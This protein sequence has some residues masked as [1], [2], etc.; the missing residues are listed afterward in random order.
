M[1]KSVSELK[2]DAENLREEIAKLRFEHALGKLKDT[3][4][5]KKKRRELAKVLTEVSQKEVIGGQDV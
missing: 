2:T 5:L 1:E 4:Q 3:N